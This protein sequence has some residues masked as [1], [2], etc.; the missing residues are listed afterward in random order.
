MPV[1]TDSPSGWLDTDIRYV[2]FGITDTGR[3]DSGRKRTLMS[4]YGT[5]TRIPF[6]LKIQVETKTS[7]M[8]TPVAPRS[9]NDP[10]AD[11]S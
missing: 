4:P 6:T 3:D 2:G 7:V 8:V 1:N 5:T 9:C 10:V 11:G